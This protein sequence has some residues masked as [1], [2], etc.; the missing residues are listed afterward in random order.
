M[1]VGFPGCVC[2]ARSAPLEV[3]L[4]R[5]GELLASAPLST[6]LTRHI[7]HGVNSDQVLGCAPLLGVQEPEVPSLQVL[8]GSDGVVV[9]HQRAPPSITTVGPVAAIRP[10]VNLT[11]Q[12]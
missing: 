9:G 2:G 8:D 3:G 7:D 6:T 5:E 1:G 12:P 11:T 10:P 4:Q